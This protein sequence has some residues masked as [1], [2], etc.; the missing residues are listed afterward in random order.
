MPELRL[1]EAEKVRKKI[2]VSQERHIRQLYREALGHVKD[3][4][5]SL[6][7]RDN[8]SSV[9]RRHYL[10]QMEKELSEEMEKIGKDIESTILDNISLTAAAVVKDTNSALNGFGLYLNGAYSFVPTDVVQ[11]IATG[12][13]YSGDW[14][15][16][17][18]IW[19]HSKKSQQDIHDIIAKGVLENKSSFDIAKDLEKY[20]NPSA[21]K[22]WD[23]GK[24]YPGTARKID[25]NAQRLA[26]TLVSHA[27]Q[28][29]F[30][31]TT[32][33]NPF[34]EGYKWL[35]ANNHR[36]C[37][38]CIDRAENV[39]VE[40][41]PEGVYSKDDVPLDHPNGQCTLAVY[42]TQDTD[43]IVDALVNWAHGGEDEGL[44]KFAESLGFPIR[45]VKMSISRN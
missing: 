37:P 35:T 45:E 25:Y 20:V 32:K 14:T 17:N 28:Q 13:I 3:W 31:K 30:V 18:A 4:S 5:K 8:V 41:F 42:M 26:R 10:D 11:A 24:V 2:T 23:W 44:D 7:G 36:V 22:P 16:S 21:V 34:F 15:L 43:Q 6:E 9:L 12:Q 29:S 27:Y 33:D 40:G 1:L 19:Q 39:H 38:I